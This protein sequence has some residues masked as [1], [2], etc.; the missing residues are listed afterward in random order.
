[1]N[2]WGWVTLSL[3]LF[4][5]C[6]CMPDKREFNTSYEGE[7]LNRI[8]FPIGGLGTGMFCIE[9]TGA[10]SHMS[11][12]HQPDLFHEPCMF[13][14]IHVRGME[15]GT[16]VLEKE[17]PDWKKYGGRGAA[18]G[19]GE[20]TWGL[21]RF[22]EGV[23]SSRFPFAEIKLKDK[24]IPLDV[25]LTGWSPFI[26][27][28]EDNS[29]IPAGAIE[30]TFKNN[31][32]AEVEAVFSYNSKNFM[33]QGR[34]GASILPINN[35]FILS[36]SGSDNEPYRQGDFAVFTDDPQTKVDYLWFRGG[37]FDPLSVKWNDIALGNITENAYEPGSPGG[38]LYV[39]F[40]L[41][42]NE[43]KTIRLY[44]TWYVPYSNIRI[45]G[46]PRS[47]NDLPSYNPDAAGMDSVYRA[48]A[49]S[50]NYRP[51]Y[52]SK[53]KDVKEVSSYWQ[54]NYKDLKEKTQL[55]TNTFY[56]NTLPAEV[57][58]A[59]AAN[60]TILKSSTVFRQYDG[61]LWNW[62]GS[63][64]T[65]G[66]CH[67]S[68][69][70]VWNYAQAVP[71]LFPN[72]ERTLRETE[73]LVSQD[74]RGHQA[75]RTNL[76][77]RPVVHDFHSAADGQL[78]GIMKIYRD[79]RIY[80]NNDWLR[81]MYP[82]V[83][84]SLDYCI[85]VWDP[86]ETGALEEPHHNTYDIEFWGPNGMC[87]SFYT[88]ALQALVLMGKTLDEDINR[89]ESLLAK[90][91]DYMENK[92]FDG[93][94]FIQDTRWKG[95]DAP[96]PTKLQSFNSGY[97]K[98]A[99]VLLEKE[100]PKYQYGKGCL[101][102]G[103][104]GSWMSLVC[105][106]PEVID[107]NKITSHLVSVHK[108]NLKKDLLDHANPQRPTFAMGDDGGLLLCSWPK[109]GKLQLPFVY[110][111]EV[112]TGIEYQVAS[113]LMFEGEVEKGLE[114]VRTCRERYD[115][116]IRNPFNEYEC[117]AWYARAMSSFG[118]LEGLTGIR[119]DAVDGILYFDSRIGDN[120]TSFISTNTGFGNAGLKN[121]KPFIDVKSGSIDVK[122][123]I[124]SGVE[125]LL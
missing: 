48:T 58:E 46:D 35:G 17:V 112:W 28:D 42:P 44:M 33:Q 94:Y 61:R 11:L 16:K 18:L 107:K 77:I 56:N 63:G 73:F 10:I 72:M 20:M 69:T 67:G 34:D 102:D 49:S 125:A 39:P 15:N 47:E 54:S 4:Q 22:D 7:Y 104:L 82:S 121:G 96:D 30:Y 93:E 90:S 91:K 26:P 36:Q 106:M 80:G 116:R 101:S 40:K 59:I 87:T 97:S 50:G 108:Y 75:F 24:D 124:V 78:G 115:G 27:A 43:E 31:S 68:C 1:M 23:F 81:K 8:A 13:A 122:K 57:T 105:G 117:G 60:L 110:S 32:S 64:D 76:P 5:A 119:Y 70:H 14:A 88:G 100:G 38:S 53:F 123:C 109:G 3:F 9:G 29:S 85:S 86:R 62:E 114:I 21:P 89:Y 103:V 83:K 120:F 71:H 41:A 55:F 111:D 65:W 95:L 25:T 99:L 74:N 98:E 79:W 118:M 92:L 113:H 2:K 51:W 19:N 12:R 66:S 37:W 45:G 84:Q 52:S 6:N